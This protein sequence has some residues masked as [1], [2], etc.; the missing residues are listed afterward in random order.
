M[1]RGLLAACCALFS[2]WCL[3]QRAKPPATCPIQP[4]ECQVNAQVFNFGRHEMTANSPS[5][6]SNATISVTCTRRLASQQGTD[7]DVIFD[8]VALPPQPARQMRDRIGGA[9]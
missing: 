1:T 3:A 2:C 4:A 6:D 9:Y 8:L 7:V 5:V